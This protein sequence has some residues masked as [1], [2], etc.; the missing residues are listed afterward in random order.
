MATREQQITELQHDWDSNPRWNGVTRAYSAAEVVRQR[1]SLRIEHTL[2][3]RGAGKLWQLL[4]SEPFVNALGAQTGQQALQ[5]VRAGLKAI[6]LSGGEMLPPSMLV[7][8]IN[9][10][11]QRGDREQWADGKG[12]IDFFAPIVADADADL[13]PSMIEAG[14]AGVHVDD[15]L[16]GA[17]Q[18]VLLPTRAAVERLG[19]VRMAADVMGVPTLLIARTDAAAAGLLASDVDD[20]DRPF[21]TGERTAEGYYHV[22]SGLEQAV[23]RALA[24]A[25]YADLLWCETARPDL[26]FAQQFAAAV[27]ARF[28]GKMLAYNCPPSFNWKQNLDDATIARFQKELG[29]MGYKFQFITLAGVHA[30]NYGM[31]TLAHGYARRQLPAFVELQEA[32]FAAAERGFSVV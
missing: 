5:Q 11:L 22:R 10:A 7:K 28:P 24:Y 1:G 2:A 32:E 17:K 25:P 15:L 14:V 20:G 19:A 4:N 27:H 9:H 23:A 29:T 18:A 8:R 30:L 21:C 16:P 26:V 6:Y 12:A 13:M 3:Q 31:F